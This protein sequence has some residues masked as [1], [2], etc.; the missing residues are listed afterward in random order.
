MTCPGCGGANPS[1]Y[2]ECVACGELLVDLFADAPASPAS[3]ALDPNDLAARTT[4]RLL[5]ETVFA[6]RY[7]ILELLGEGGMG[8]VYKARDLELGK[9]IALK[10]IR[11][12]KGGDPTVVERFKQELLLARKITHK[13]VVRIHDLGQADGV[14]FFTMELVEGDTLKEYIRK[15]DKIPVK[16]SI[17]M[18]MQILSGLEEAHRQGVVHRDLK[19][20]NI[21]VT[22]EGSPVIMDFGIARSAESHQLT[23]TGA[24]MGTPD[25]MSPEAVGGQTIDAQSDLFSFGVIFFE[26]LTGELPYEADTAMSRIIVRLTAKPRTPRELNLEVPK[27]LE[28]LVLK[29]MEIDKALRYATASEILRDLEREHVD[30]TLVRRIS[31]HFAR[32]RGALLAVASFLMVVGAVAYFGARPSN[33]AAQV[34]ADERVT[35]LAIL[36]LTNATGAV[37]LEWMRTGIADML[38]T[39]V[40]QSRYL[41]P[42]PSERVAKLLREL[43]VEDRAR[44]DEATVESIS[45]LAPAQLV[46]HG[47]FVESEGTIRLDLALRRAGSGVSLPIK[48]EGQASQVFAL[49]DRIT[50]EVKAHIDLSPELLAGDVDRPV[51]EVATA[52]IDALR[53][54]QAG[55]AQLR[56]GANL[57]AVERFREATVADPGFAMAHVKLAETQWNAGELEPARSAAEKAVKLAASSALPLYERYQI[58]AIAAQVK[59]DAD[60]AVLSYREL[61]DLYPRDPDILL[62]LAGSLEN[63]GSVPEAME[64]YRRVLEL[65]PGYGAALLG[66][67]RAQVVSGQM[68][69][70]IASLTEVLESGQ[71]DEDAE[72]LGM[73]H[74]ILGVAYRD[75]GEVEKA[76]EN[77]H[78]SLEFR[79]QTGNKRGQAA[80]LTNLAGLYRNRGYNDEAL[81]AAI[82]AA[83]IARQMGDR[84]YES[85]AL[86]TLGT[87]Y[88][89]KG[90]LDKALEAFRESFQ[91]EMDRGE[92]TEL[93]I[94]MNNIADIYRIRGQYAD[95]L[96][97]LEQAKTHL[98]RAEDKQE[99]G[100]NLTGIGLVKKSQGRYEEAIVSLLDALP[101]FREIG[102]SSYAAEVQMYLGQIYLDQGRYADAFQALGQSQM[103]FEEIAQNVGLAEVKLHLA[104]LL[105]AVGQPDLAAAKLDQAEGLAGAGDQSRAPLLLL[106]RAELQHDLGALEQARVSAN[107]AEEEAARQGSFELAAEAR[108][109]RARIDIK[110][111]RLT[112]AIDMLLDVRQEAAGRF[113]RRQE[114]EA[115]SAL[116]E[117]YLARGDALGAGATAV[118]AI[119]AAKAFTGR[120]LLFR[121]YAILGVARDRMQL[122]DDALDAYSQMASILNEI[123]VNLAPDHGRSYSEQIDEQ[124]LIREAIARL[125]DSGRQEVVAPLEAWLGR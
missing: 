88:M 43:G 39:D 45:K 3:M 123:R 56:R 1:D 8:R 15:R 26:M 121:T 69:E 14:K 76:L 75:T 77:L 124:E 16:D 65:E 32:R 93:A 84:P 5:R 49:V 72:G 9:N 52:S 59:D 109:E 13:N 54:Y 83:A 118:E 89:A 125:N 33:P 37:G 67:G 18:A 51:V 34:S 79:R 48:V 42:V 27:H 120:P 36:P 110:R 104:R 105:V 29:C 78:L 19:P 41:R 99:K 92:H 107:S 71:F 102:R 23:A 119:E 113:L 94:R 70:A 4:A 61:A 58:H 44:F 53:L 100:R 91:I 40:S 112:E 66:L 103:I 74:S 21:M 24:V 20:Q 95:A 106:A 97:Y 81:A 57:V 98:A 111:R 90:N 55:L 80:T 2:V 85:F 22:P 11:S 28:S 47:Q 7:Q 12:E 50:Q 87:T 46:L 115:L 114:A 73:I 96:V 117:G 68:R 63:L 31:R 101:L 86:N 6:G 17:A 25:Y 82:D 108:I 116:A 35:T 122:P 10:T 62:S 38:V 64:A 60:T 30:R